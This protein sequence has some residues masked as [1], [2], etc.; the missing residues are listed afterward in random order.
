[1]KYKLNKTRVLTVCAVISLCRVF[2]NSR[3]VGLDLGSCC[4]HC[5][6]IEYLQV[7]KQITT[8]EK[9]RTRTTKVLLV[10]TFYHF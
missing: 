3:N 10:R 9:L 8:M 2:P 1:M 5:H 6:M 4:Q 7:T